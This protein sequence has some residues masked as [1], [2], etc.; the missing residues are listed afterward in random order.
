MVV[1]D[2][3]QYG[4]WGQAEAARREHWVAEKTKEIK[5]STVR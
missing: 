4:L 2:V 3:T 1:H 5:D